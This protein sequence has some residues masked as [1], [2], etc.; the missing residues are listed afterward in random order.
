MKK[1]LF[2]SLTLLLISFLWGCDKEQPI[3]PTIVNGQ[4]LEQGSN[5]PLEGVKVVLMEGTYGGLGSGTYSF[6]PV[7]TFF[8]D[9]DGK[10][11]YEHTIPFDKKVYEL[12]Y[13]KDKYFDLS[14]VSENDRI[15][16][17]DY[18]KTISPV[19]KMFPFAWLTIRV[20]NEKPFDSSDQIKIGGPW[21]AASGD[22]WYY[23]NNVN[24]SF[25][26]MTKGGKKSAVK[27]FVYKNNNSQSFIDSVFLIPNDTTFY[28][29]KY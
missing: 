5:K 9:K 7:D 19:T 17:V 13:F 2:F 6:Y 3:L 10:Y 21:E 25:T 18:N 1:L 4:V 14:N 20:V 27:W 12:W 8:T 22:D 26:K 16:R 29:I 11:S 23:G 24:D 15:T 28:T